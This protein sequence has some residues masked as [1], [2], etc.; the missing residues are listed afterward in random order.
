MMFSRRMFVYTF[1]KEKRIISTYSIFFLS[2][3]LDSKNPSPLTFCCSRNLDKSQ[4][5]KFDKKPLKQTHS[6][7]IAGMVYAKETLGNNNHPFT[8]NYYVTLNSCHTRKF[9]SCLLYTSDAA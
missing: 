9:Y 8:S 4:T 1:I 2:V 7:N 5:R 6:H 3:R